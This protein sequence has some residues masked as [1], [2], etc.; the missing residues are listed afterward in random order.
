MAAGRRS[1][2]PAA[3][4]DTEEVGQRELRGAGMPLSG[5][6]KSSGSAGSAL[7]HSAGD[8]DKILDQDSAAIGAI[9][10][11]PGLTHVQ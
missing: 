7:A 11:A 8:A 4:A 3:D 10:A 9:M 5:G 6:S 2:R 1:A